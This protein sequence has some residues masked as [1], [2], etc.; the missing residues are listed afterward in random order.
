MLKVI[1]SAAILDCDLN[2]MSR[3]GLPC[4]QTGAT[5][6]RAYLGRQTRV[7]QLKGCLLGSITRIYDLWDESLNKR[8]VHG[9]DT[10][11]GQEGYMA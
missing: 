6:Y 11:C 8:K 9:L 7:V 5:H 3:G 4:P 2:S 10:C 1:P